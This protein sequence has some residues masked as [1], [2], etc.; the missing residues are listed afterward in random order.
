[1]QRS[2]ELNPSNQW[3]VADMGLV[4]TY[5]G[6][7]EEAPAWNARARQID[8]YFD[9][10]WYWRQ[11]GI[12]C[13]VLG[14]YQ[15]AAAL[16]ARSQI[17]G[18]RGAA[19]MAG[20][21]ARLGDMERARAFAAQCLALRPDFTIRQFM[22]K[23]PFKLES[24][25]TRIIESLRL[26]GL[27]DTTEPAWVEQVLDFWFRKIGAIHW[28]SRSAE[29]DDEIRARFLKLHEEL[30]AAEGEGLDSRRAM[31]AAVVVLDQFSRN[32]F[33]GSPQAFAAD[34]LAR[35]LARQAIERGL[36]S[37]FSPEERLFL[38]LP[39]EHSE[40]RDDQAYSCELI[41]RLG[42]DDWTRYAQAHKAIIDRFG[43]FPHRNAALGRTSTAEELALLKEPMGSF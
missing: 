43:R 35:R 9:E 29:I 38:Y 8:P 6:R 7:A 25:A 24:D 11:S 33:R 18:Y 21:Q 12:A 14:R 23:E 3:N 28:F 39:F 40:D 36:D 31:L 4:L 16:L 37:G 22:S 34:P 17:L 20:C 41:G 1:M 32:M 5:I 27:P 26:A 19:L 10:P 13:M 42:N 30:V 2:V 15:E